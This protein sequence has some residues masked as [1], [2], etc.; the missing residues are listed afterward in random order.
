MKNEAH[1]LKKES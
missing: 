1:S